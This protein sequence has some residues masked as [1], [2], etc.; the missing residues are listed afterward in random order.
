MFNVLSGQHYGNVVSGIDTFYPNHLQ[1]APSLSGTETVVTPTVPLGSEPWSTIVS[2]VSAEQVAQGLYILPDVYGTSTDTTKVG[3]EIAVGSFALFRVGTVHV[4]GQ[5]SHYTSDVH[6]GVQLTDA[7]LESSYDDA[8]GGTLSFFAF[9]K[10]PA[11]M[12]DSTVNSGFSVVQTTW[13]PEIYLIA[14]M[15]PLKVD[16]GTL[17]AQ[18]RALVAVGSPTGQRDAHWGEWIDFIGAGEPPPPPT[19]EPPLP[20]PTEPPP[21]VEPDEVDLEAVDGHIESMELL[22]EDARDFLSAAR[23]PFRANNIAVKINKLAGAVD[24]ADDIGSLVRKNL[25]FSS[26]ADDVD[27]TPLL[28]WSAKAVAKDI[29]ELTIQKYGSIAAKGLAGLGAAITG[30]KTYSETGDVGQAFTDSGVKFIAALASMEAGKLAGLGAAGVVASVSGASLVIGTGLPVLVG[31]T[32][33]FAVGAG[34]E[35]IIEYSANQAGLY[36]YD[37]FDEQQQLFAPQALSTSPESVSS[38]ALGDPEPTPKW[39]YN[40]ETGEF[41]WLDS[42]LEARFPELAT[43]LGVNPDPTPLSLIGDR[44]AST[45]D[46]VLFGHDGDDS[47]AGG[48]GDDILDGAVGNDGLFGGSGSDIILGGAGDDVARGQGGRD[49]LEGG[50]GMDKLFGNGGNDSIVGR[51]GAD[52]LFGGGGN[53]ILKGGGGKDTL[54]AGP[55]ADILLGGAG[56]DT[57]IYRNIAHAGNGASKDVIKRFE[58]GTDILRLTPIDADTTVAGNQSFT[59]IAD[60]D[61]AAAGELRYDSGILAG[62]VNGDGKAD[63]QIRF[64]TSVDLWA[65]DMLM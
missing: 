28:D 62:D 16:P 8:F 53:D 12:T 21:P 45:V 22:A 38:L 24:E 20:P 23:V 47:M 52:K 5:F 2:E 58:V 46:D 33:G 34:V 39:E 4:D 40:L 26:L 51:G 17:T 11:W 14:E 25:M 19:P 30:Y 56:A 48:I 64:G 65:D 35:M 37:P 63:F 32:V 61:F 49:F 29:D 59:F 50:P 13:L 10:N 55:G 18:G 44:F 54:I 57:F 27:D 42:E 41:K 15:G 6:D 3:A 9:D 7:L 1:G 43:A 31:L 60:G 36:S